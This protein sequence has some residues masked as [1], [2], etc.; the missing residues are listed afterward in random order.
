MN[1]Y[2]AYATSKENGISVAFIGDHLLYHPFWGNQYLSTDRPIHETTFVSTMASK[3]LLSQKKNLKITAYD[4]DNL[5]RSQ[6]D[7]R[8]ATLELADHVYAPIDF[9]MDMS[10]MY[11]ESSMT[12]YRDS[13]KNLVKYGLPAKPAINQKF[14][15]ESRYINAVKTM[16]KVHNFLKRKKRGVKY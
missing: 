7:D 12:F 9:K 5:T 2:N 15:I 3:L 16:N 14:P 10:P 6:I 1:I 13:W 11:Y 8:R 4:Y